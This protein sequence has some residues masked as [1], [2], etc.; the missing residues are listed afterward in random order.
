VKV[1]SRALTAA[2]IAAI[3]ADTGL[4]SSDQLPVSQK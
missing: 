3:Y 1:F 2:E 4:V